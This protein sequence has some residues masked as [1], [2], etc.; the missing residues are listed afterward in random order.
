M[1]KWLNK[2]RYDSAEVKQLFR[3]ATNI[4]NTF[5]N[6]SISLENNNLF[7]VIGERGASRL[8]NA[9]KILD[10]LRAAK[11]MESIGNV[12]KLKD[13]VLGL[14]HKSAKGDVVNK[15]ISIGKL[16]K[17]GREY[18]AGIS[19]LSF[20]EEIDFMLNPSDL[21]HIYNN[22]YGKNE[23]DKGN[24]K[25]LNDED[26][27]SIVDVVH[28]PDEVV[29][30]GWDKRTQSNKFAFLKKSDAGTYNLLEVYSIKNGNLT[31]KTFLNVKKSISQRVMELKRPLLSTSETYF[32][33]SSLTT[34]IPQL[35]ESTKS[36]DAKTIRLATGWERG[37]DGKWRYETR[38][39]ELKKDID[40]IGK[41]KT[42]NGAFAEEVP[43]TGV[44][45]D[46]ELFNSYP[47]L[48]DVKLVFYNYGSHPE[49]A[50]TGAFSDLSKK[51][52]GIGTKNEADDQFI[53]DNM[54]SFDDETDNV[55]KDIMDNPEVKAIIPEYSKNGRLDVDKLLTEIEENPGFYY[56]SIRIKE[57]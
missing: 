51:I 54:E 38:D 29:F 15:S 50:G 14:F 33:E 53:T 44:I 21:K 56:L 26:I 45:E 52:I 23:K 46:K 35:F 10:G 41:L 40:F 4:I 49:L 3:H 9:E 43:L 42:Q 57:V 11:E 7:R 24:N 28:H 6:P 27:R 37:K 17:K 34:N 12:D 55:V 39:I 20:K 2:Q 22:H 31:A 36:F 47:Q 8:N 48:K 13:V 25:P 16:T 5:K 30:L 1:S 19:G 32:G 18:L